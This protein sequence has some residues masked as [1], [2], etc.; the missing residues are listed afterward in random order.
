MLKRIML[1]NYRSC[2]RTSID[3]HPNLSVLI[4]PNGSGKTNILQ[5]MMLLNHMA[6]GAEHAP[7][8]RRLTTTSC[9]WKAAGE[10][11]LGHSACYRVM[12]VASCSADHMSD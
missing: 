12:K 6:R 7:G 10:P 5:G 3:L 9:K 11:N 8:L 1:E 2:L 4:G